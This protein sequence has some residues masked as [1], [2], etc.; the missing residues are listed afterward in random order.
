MG[1]NF[2]KLVCPESYL[3][4][5]SPGDTWQCLETPFV[6]ANSGATASRDQGAAPPRPVLRTA[7]PQCNLAPDA[8]SAESGDPEPRSS[9]TAHGPGRDRGLCRFSLTSSLRHALRAGLLLS[10][11]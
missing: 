8:S 11:F 3:A 7:P 4:S 1:R 6:V 2:G 10:P 9:H 5:L